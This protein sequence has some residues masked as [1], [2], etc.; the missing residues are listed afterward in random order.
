LISM[1]FVFPFPV[2]G[3]GIMIKSPTVKV[4][5]LRSGQ[6][7]GK[8][9]RSRGLIFIKFFPDWRVT[10][11]FEELKNHMAAGEKFLALE[12]FQNL[13]LMALSLQTDFFA[14][15]AMFGGTALRIFHGLPRFSEDLD[16]T[17]DQ[18]VSGFSLEPYRGGLSRFFEE[19]GLGKVTINLKDREREVAS[20]S[21]VLT[22][23]RSES[24]RVKIDAEKNRLAIAPETE[25]LYGEFPFQ[26]PARVCKL[27][28]GFAGKMDALLHRQWGGK[29]VKGRDWYDLLWYLRKGAEINLPWLEERLRAKGTLSP[30]E[31]LSP[32]LLGELY[33]K[34]AESLNLKEILRDVTVFMTDD[35]EKRA[36][37][38]W[39]AEMFLNQR[40]KIVDAA[41]KF[42]PQ[43][44]SGD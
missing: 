32:E 14:F 23:G 3:S 35:L 33:A 37:A 41:R 27:S 7:P 38:L 29:R 12:K 19:I 20:G 1:P 13:I 22:V 18:E 36:S 30:E 5:S 34:R 17:V 40:E 28:S 16:F 9:G 10:T 2:Y 44:D 39:S 4:F 26:Y 25:T 43:K 31:T 6:Q 8:R 24:L 21:I 15:A 42:K 11:I